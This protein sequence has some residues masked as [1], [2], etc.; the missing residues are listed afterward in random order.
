[1]GLISKHGL[2]KSFRGRDSEMLIYN[3]HYYNLV[4][5]IN[6]SLLLIHITHLFVVEYGCEEFCRSDRQL[7]DYLG[8]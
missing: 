1:M 3:R 2:L 7:G 8:S 4:G 6:G 5:S